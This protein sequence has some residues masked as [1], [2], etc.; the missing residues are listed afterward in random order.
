MSLILLLPAILSLLVMAAHTMRMG[1]P[2]LMAI[3]LAVILAL[4][5]PRKWVARTAQIVLIL[6][7]LEWI[8]ATLV[9]VAARQ[10]HDMPWIRLAIILGSVALVTLLSALVFQSKTLRR[11]YRLD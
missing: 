8:R 7:G 4:V 11:R 5:W 2:F 1:T 10:N 3:P 9:Y 6:G